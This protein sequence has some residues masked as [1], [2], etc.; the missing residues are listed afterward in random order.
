MTEVWKCDSCGRITGDQRPANDCCEISS[1][2]AT[3]IPSEQLEIAVSGLERIGWNG[4]L[5]YRAGE[6]A[7]MARNT[8]TALQT[9]KEEK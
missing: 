3:L 2:G 9:E 4:D 6:D 8:L 5:S 1:S 7:A